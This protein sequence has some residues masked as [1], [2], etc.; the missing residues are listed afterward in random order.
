VESLVMPVTGRC[1]DAGIFYHF[2]HSWI[3]EIQR[4]LNGGQL[5]SDYYALAEQ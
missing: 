5:P 2:H 4:V 3:E 1:V